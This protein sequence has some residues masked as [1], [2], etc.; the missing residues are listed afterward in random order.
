MGQ[1]ALKGLTGIEKSKTIPPYINPV[2]EALQK[3]IANAFNLYLN[4]KHYQ[5]L[6]SG[7]LY[8]DL[9]VIFDEFANEVY[10]TINVLTERVRVIGEKRARV[11]DFPEIAT[12]Q[13]AEKDCDIR[14]MMEEAVSNVLIVIR[15]IREAIKISKH[16]DTVSM[17]VLT[18]FLKLHEKHEWWLS[19]I[20]EKR[21]G[22]KTHS[23]N[24]E[25]SFKAG[26]KNALYFL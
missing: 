20:L 16:I 2:A 1:V 18:N 14:Q 4:Y 8:R 6:A 21:G 12:V 19:Y 10:G 5:W 3:Q 26:K 13:P 24:Q 17:N 9:N 25:L 15:E 22:L 7:P 23:E 11:R